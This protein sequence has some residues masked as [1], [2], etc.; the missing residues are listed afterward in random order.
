MTAP[1]R[2]DTSLG[3]R[4]TAFPASSAGTTVRSGSANGKFHGAITTMTP[5]ASRER[6]PRFLGYESGSM[7]MTRS[8]RCS[9][10]ASHQ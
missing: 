10:I 6:V 8:T 1:V 4:I 3:F 5:R 7:S 2:A 9:S